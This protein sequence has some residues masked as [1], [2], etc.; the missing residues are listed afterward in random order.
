MGGW[1]MP[2][3]RDCFVL[4]GFTVV[5]LSHLLKLS[6]LG[7]LD[8]ELG[9]VAL[10]VCSPYRWR[11]RFRGFRGYSLRDAGIFACNIQKKRL[12]NGPFPV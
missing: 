6:N 12:V 10:R 3:E 2:L 8:R 1:R 5:V 4:R 9:R 7:S 11:G